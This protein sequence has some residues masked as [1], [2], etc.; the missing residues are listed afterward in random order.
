MAT[1]SAANPS[2]HQMQ[3]L[4]AEQHQNLVNFL[5]MMGVNSNSPHATL[6]LSGNAFQSDQILGHH[7]TIGLLNQQPQ[8]LLNNNSDELLMEQ[9]NNAKHQRL[10][11][12]VREVPLETTTIGI[13]GPLG[14]QKQLIKLECPAADNDASCGTPPCRLPGAARRPGRRSSGTRSHP[15]RAS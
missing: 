4:L 12:M 1:A 9:Q 15:A 3:S 13:M 7:R 8:L 2:S 10:E 6:F 14:E 11:N 5:L